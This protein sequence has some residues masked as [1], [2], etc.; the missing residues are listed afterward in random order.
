MATLSKERRDW[1]YTVYPGRAAEMIREIESL[2]TEAEANKMVSRLKEAINAEYSRRSPSEHPGVGYFGEAFKSVRREPT[3]ADL[4][5]MQK[6]LNKRIKAL[7]Q[8]QKDAAETAEAQAVLDLLELADRL[9]LNQDAVMKLVTEYGL[10]EV[11]GILRTLTQTKATKGF[12][13]DAFF[14]TKTTRID[15]SDIE[16]LIR[17]KQAKSD[18]DSFF[19]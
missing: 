1:L 5:Q 4:Q 19:Y 10:S 17:T 14:G 3:I 15:V 13:V 7:G 2:P 9:E 11:T 18:R 6:S 12:F 16:T 8:A